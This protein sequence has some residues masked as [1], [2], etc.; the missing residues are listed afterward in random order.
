LLFEV[1]V[2]VHS[3][4]DEQVAEEVSHRFLIDVGHKSI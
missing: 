4:I 3:N 1:Q 2:V